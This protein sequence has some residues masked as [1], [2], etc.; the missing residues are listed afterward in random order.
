MKEKFKSNGRT[1]GDVRNLTSVLEEK[2]NWEFICQGCKKTV[3]D[4]E[5]ETVVLDTWK[6]FCNEDCRELFYN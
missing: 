5:Q 4:G 3:A 1:F 2:G 6:W